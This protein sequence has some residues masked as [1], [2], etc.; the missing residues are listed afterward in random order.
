MDTFENLHISEMPLSS[1]YFRA[2]VECFLG[3][4]GLRM[5]HLDVYG[6]FDDEDAKILARHGISQDIIKGIAVASKAWQ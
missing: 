6:A 2:K 5:A 1:P 4:N 3:E